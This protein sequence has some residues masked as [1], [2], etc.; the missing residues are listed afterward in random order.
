MVDALQ[1]LRGVSFVTAV[2]LVVGGGD[3]RRF[4]HPRQ[5]MAFLGLVPSEYSSGPSVRRGGITKAGNPHARRLLAEAAWAYQ[6]VPR[7]GRQMLYRQEALPKVICD[8]AWK[9][10]LR[11]TSRF[12]K[13]AARGKAKPKVATA[14]ARELTGF[15]WA[16]AREIPLPPA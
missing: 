10:Q 5:L 11:L 4:D 9:A 16:I 8:I 7:I 2:G 1:A 13:L 3:I 15:I 14:I 6:G 12:R